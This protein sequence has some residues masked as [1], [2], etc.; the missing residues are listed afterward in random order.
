MDELDFDKIMKGEDQ[1]AQKKEA[2]EKAKKLTQTDTRARQQSCMISEVNKDLV[3]VFWCQLP[4]NTTSA[5]PAG[6]RVSL[7]DMLNIVI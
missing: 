1:A 6:F 2:E 4:T 3:I 7:S 5:N